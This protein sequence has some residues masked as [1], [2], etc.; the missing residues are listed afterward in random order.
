MSGWKNI[1]GLG[2]FLG[3]AYLQGGALYHRGWGGEL[4]LMLQEK[5]GKDDDMLCAG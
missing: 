4:K 5:R 2:F 1:R 3:G